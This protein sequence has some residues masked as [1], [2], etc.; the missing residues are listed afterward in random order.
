[1]TDT[2]TVDVNPEG[3][4]TLTVPERFEA[5]GAF[6]VVLDNHGE[7]AHVYL[8]LDDEL[9]GAATLEATNY[10]VEQSETLT[11]T[12]S[13]ASNAAASG[14]LTVATAYG[15]EKRLVP[16]TVEPAEQ[17]KQ[18]VEIDESLASPGGRENSSSRS[19][20]PSSDG[21]TSTSTSSSTSISTSESS[22]SPDE[23]AIRRLLPAIVFG[24]IALILALSSLF[25]TGTSRIVLGV[26]A[27]LAGVFVVVYLTLV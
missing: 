5:Q 15:N 21:S 26:L 1:M 8:N 12:I 22:L 13:V 24:G 7:P 3:M 20:G 9:S 23:Q 10:Y 16:I 27:V 11:V 18:P 14:D 2:L 25:I 4:H 6:E 19:T 17:R